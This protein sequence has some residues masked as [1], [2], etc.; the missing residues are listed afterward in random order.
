MK[1]LHVQQIYDP[2]HTRF[3]TSRHVYKV[4][5]VINATVPPIGE[6]ISLQEVNNYCSNEKWQVTII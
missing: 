6:T 5:K 1:R 4:I 3:G 2:D